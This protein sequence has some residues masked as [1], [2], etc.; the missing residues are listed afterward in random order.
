MVKGNL[1]FAYANG[2]DVMERIVGC[3]RMDDGVTEW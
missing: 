3:P 1:S 2:Y